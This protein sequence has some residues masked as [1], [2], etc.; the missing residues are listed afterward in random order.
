M[1]T[2]LTLLHAA[3][4]SFIASQAQR[5]WE[6]VRTADAAP[7][8]YTVCPGSQS[9]GMFFSCCGV[10]LAKLLHERAFCRIV[11]G[12]RGRN[13]IPKKLPGMRAADNKTVARILQKFHCYS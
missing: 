8:H 5:R 4:A 6:L 1:T 9:F 12:C 10:I 11:A 3:F 13:S 2:A 7:H